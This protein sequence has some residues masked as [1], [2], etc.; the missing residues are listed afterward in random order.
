MRGISKQGLVVV[1]GGTGGVGLATSTALLSQGH[2]VVLC[3]RNPQTGLSAVQQLKSDGYGSVAL[4]IVDIAALGGVNSAAQA[5]VYSAAA[6]LGERDTPTPISCLI[7]NAG[8]GG[9]LP[10]EADP[11]ANERGEQGRLIL[12]TNYTGTRDMTASMEP[13]LREDAVV[14]NLSS[15]AA[16]GNISKMAP[17]MLQALRGADEA[18]LDRLAEGFLERYADPAAPLRTL[19]GPTG[20]Y[21]QVC[22][23]VSSHPSTLC[24]VRHTGSQRL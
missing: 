1:T 2:R 18:G 8:V 20:Y 3:A 16:F 4:A 22:H 10:W 13:L 11:A 21:L 6:E 23:V 5:A 7:N 19:D 15:G 17:E 24:F 9:D 14:V 12:R